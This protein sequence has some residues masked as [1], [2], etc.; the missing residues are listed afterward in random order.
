MPGPM[1]VRLLPALPVRVLLL[2]A[3]LA[4][5]ALAGGTGS[6]RG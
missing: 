2:A 6:H 5:R 3:S 1:P 4:A